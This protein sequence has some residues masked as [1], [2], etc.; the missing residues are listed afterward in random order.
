MLGCGTGGSTALFNGIMARFRPEDFAPR[1]SCAYLT[2]HTSLPEEWPI[3]FETMEPF[4]A[5]AEQLFRVRG[6]RDPLAPGTNAPLLPPESPSELDAHLLSRFQR[7]NLHSYITPRAREKLPGCTG[8]VMA[9]CPRECRNDARRICVD[10]ALQSYGAQLLPNCLV[11]R[12]ETKGQTVR[13]ASCRWIDREIRIRA[14]M[15]I[16]SANAFFSPAV[17]QRS[18]SERYP[19]G[20]AS[21]SSMLGR[22][23]MMHVSDQILLKPKKGWPDFP[24]EMN[25]GISLND[26]YL[27][28]GLKLGNINGLAASLPPRLA[29]T[30]RDA[31]I[32]FTTILED[33]PYE[34]NRVVAHPTQPGDVIWEYSAPHELRYRSKLLIDAFANA[35]RDDFE[36]VAKLPLGRLNMTHACGTCRFGDDPQSN[37]LDRECRV[38]S[39]DNLYVLDSSF[40]PSSGGI[41]PSLTIVANSLRVAD[42][43]AH[44]L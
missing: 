1:R 17:L 11:V 16:L 32:E 25:E 2:E 33:F 8:C 41:N 38:H 19:D 30:S 5:E 9:L 14:R 34:R 6:T 21:E 28:D 20:I 18:T 31:P 29:S 40:L 36:V 42:T 24:L 43:I 22:N 44:R 3:D 10:R 15:F 7:A 39:V 12:F 4:Y 27:L 37:V 26:F 13:A 35:V 23:L